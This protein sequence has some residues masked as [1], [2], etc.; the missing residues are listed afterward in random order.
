MPWVAGY[1]SGASNLII[2]HPFD[3]VKVRI[4]TAEVGVFKGPFDCAVKLIKEEGIFG[5]YKGVTPPLLFKG[6]INSVMFGMYSST[7][8]F[9]NGSETPSLAS[10]FG[11]GV[12]A[13]WAALPLVVPVDQVKACLQVQYKYSN[14]TEVKGPIDCARQ[15]ANRF[16][17]FG[18]IYRYWFLTSLEMTMMGFFFSSYELS[19]RHLI[20]T[21][22][23]LRGL[24]TN[25][26]T[27]MNSERKLAPI[28]SFI[29]GGVA[30]SSFWITALPIEI[31][32]YRM[33]TQP[34]D[35]PKWK[36]AIECARHILRS[37]GITAFWRGFGTAMA[38]T[39]P[40]SG[41]TFLTYEAAMKVFRRTAMRD[42][43]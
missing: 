30:G 37:E 12:I 1:I 17:I 16:G 36:T 13:G 7:C 23:R 20:S 10:S 27:S 34:F 22:D 24:N 35:A 4:Q 41:A 5:L 3:T 42:D 31:V 25:A 40:A 21:V 26:T 38:R 39:W 33:M 18:G 14:T 2:G 11:A 9:I 19:R 28:S 8:K 29:A 43:T 6:S 32:K 15:L